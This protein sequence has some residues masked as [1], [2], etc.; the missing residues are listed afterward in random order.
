M[1][2]SDLIPFENIVINAAGKSKKKILEDLSLFLSD[3]VNG[4]DPEKL[5]QSLLARERLGST[6][7]G[8]GIAIPHCRML[9][10]EKNYS[11]FF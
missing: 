8:K 7:I 10:C 2:L 9:G 4:I 3:R 11:S 5:Y 6:G 1:K